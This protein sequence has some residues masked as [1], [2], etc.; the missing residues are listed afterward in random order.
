MGFLFFVLLWLLANLYLYTCLELYFCWT[1]T[2]LEGGPLM[3]K[4]LVLCHSWPW[5][6]QDSH[7]VNHTLTINTVNLDGWIVSLAS[8][9]FITIFIRQFDLGW[10]WCTIHIYIAFKVLRQSY[11]RRYNIVLVSD[12]TP[13]RPISG[14]QR[15]VSTLTYVQ[16]FCLLG[17]SQVNGREK[18]G[19]FMT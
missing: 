18:T 16:S 3:L 4:F 10:I 7:F 15:K 2:A 9:A 13:S 14:S 6:F 5:R 12:F 1:R 17:S 11:C 19:Q 8:P